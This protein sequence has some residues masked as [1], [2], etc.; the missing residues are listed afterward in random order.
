M[1]FR[2]YKDGIAFTEQPTNHAQ[3]GGVTRGKDESS[4]PAIEFS[5]TCFKLFVKAQSAIEHSGASN[6][7]A[8]AVDRLMCRLDDTRMCGQP[9]IVVGAKINNFVPF[10]VG[11]WPR[12]SISDMKIR[13]ATDALGQINFCDTRAVEQS[14]Q[15]RLLVSCLGS[16]HSHNT[17]TRYR[18][19]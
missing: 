1:R 11:H 15:N 3:I 7:C 16:N 9:K 2:V 5:Q 10:K 18:V 13:I 8:P 6:S 12:R 19:L 14:L 17:N 4:L